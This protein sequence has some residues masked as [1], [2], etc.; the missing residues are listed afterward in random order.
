MYD[1]KIN[2]MRFFSH[3]GVHPEE[4][5]LGQQLEIDLVV[6]IRQ[7]IISDDVTN[8]ISYSRFYQ[9]VAT[10]VKNSQV[11]LVETLC[12]E[13]IHEIKKINLEKNCK[14]KVGIRKMAVPIDGIFDN[15]EIL[16]EG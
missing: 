7:G 9:V 14:V 1:I 3:I 12:H 15:V 6:Q 5:I 13:I 8:I 11:N 2:N 10:I 16:M 4:K